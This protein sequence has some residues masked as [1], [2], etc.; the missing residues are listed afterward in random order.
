MRRHYTE[1]QLLPHRISVR[2]ETLG[3]RLVDQVMR[4]VAIVLIQQTPA[5]ERNSENLKIIGG[6]PT[7][8]CSWKS[9]G[10]KAS[11]HNAETGGKAAVLGFSETHGNSVYRGDLLHTG[12]AFEFRLDA[13][14]KES[15]GFLPITVNERGWDG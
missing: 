4:L 12:K 6:R 7:R 8:L 10:L 2:K 5:D 15:I 1:E 3:E 14:P 11:P 13:I 9:A